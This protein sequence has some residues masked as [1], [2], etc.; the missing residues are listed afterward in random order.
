MIRKATAADAEAIAG[1]YNHYIQETIITFEEQPVPASDIAKRIAEVSAASLP[2]LVAEKN[3]SL[4][5]YAY[6]TKW[7]DRSAYRFSVETTI[8][9][10]PDVV[11]KGIGTSLY[12][13][14]L[15]QLK[16]LELHVAVGCIALPNSAS[17]V[18]HEKLGF[19]KVAHFSDVGFKFSKWID[20][21]Y[22]E[23]LL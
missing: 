23:L 1:I 5:G 21:A 19:R 10:D 22:W 13:A 18:L 8:Y 16:D 17:I 7:K 4:V 2:W 6:A 9:L 11:G 3:G 15:T 14:L 12:Q 20:V